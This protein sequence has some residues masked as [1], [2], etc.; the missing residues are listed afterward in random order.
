MVPLSQFVLAVEQ[1][2]LNVALHFSVVVNCM[3]QLRECL[4]KLGFDFT[5]K[6]FSLGEG[7][8]GMRG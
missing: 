3:P 2:L 4:G 7:G 6:D 8:G 5:L 1:P